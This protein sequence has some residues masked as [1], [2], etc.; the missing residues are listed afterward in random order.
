MGI[1]IDPQHALALTIVTHDP[2]MRPT[3]G[4]FDL[5]VLLPH[6]VEERFPI[7]GQDIKDVYPVIRRR[8]TRKLFGEDNGPRFSF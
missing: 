6:I 2:E 8:S 5:L 3:P 4:L 7:D 1:V